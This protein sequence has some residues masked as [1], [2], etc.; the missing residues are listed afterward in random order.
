MMNRKIDLTLHNDFSGGGAVITP[1]DD[2]D[3]VVDKDIYDLRYMSTD[4]YERLLKYEKIFGR[5]RH[6]TDEME[7]FMKSDEEYRSIRRDHC[8][9]CG[10]KH[11]IPWKITGDLCEECEEKISRKKTFKELILG[12]QSVI[13]FREA[14][15]RGRDLFALR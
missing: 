8:W 6:F 3:I 1:I 10:K 15:E 4:D 11:R 7:V 14:D 13:S 5:K 12:Y 2:F 9:R